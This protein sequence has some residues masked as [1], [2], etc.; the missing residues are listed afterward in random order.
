MTNNQSIFLAGHRGMVGRAIERH[1]RS[2]GHGDILTRPRQEL[3]LLD[4][5]AVFEYQKQAKPYTVT[6]ADTRVG[7]P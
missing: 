5:E 6:L 2:L 3:D 4:Q 7:G 1:L